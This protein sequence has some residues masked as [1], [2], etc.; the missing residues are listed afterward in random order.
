MPQ[1]QLTVCF[2]LRLL[3]IIS[4]KESTGQVAIH[5]ISTPESFTFDLKRPMRTIAL[6]PN[7]A[8]NS[9]RPFVCGGMAGNLVLYEKGWLGHKDTVLH[10]S[11]GPIWSVRW[12]ETLIAWAN[13]M[14]RILFRLN[15][16]E[17]RFSIQ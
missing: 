4:T 3:V 16:S 12:R 5:S 13:D 10:A 8:K 7:F 2:S 15:A 11:E 17:R 9:S 1:L 14:V 6:A